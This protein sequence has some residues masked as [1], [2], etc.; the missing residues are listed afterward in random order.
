[1]EDIVARGTDKTIV[2]KFQPNDEGAWIGNE[3]LV[4]EDLRSWC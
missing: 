4:D 2:E 1:M 3:G